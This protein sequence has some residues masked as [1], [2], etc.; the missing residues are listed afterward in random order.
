MREIESADVVPA[1]RVGED[2]FAVVDEVT[3]KLL[4]E[5]DVSEQC[6]SCGKNHI[7]L[8]TIDNGGVPEYVCLECLF[9][10]PIFNTIAERAVFQ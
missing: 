3:G 9:Q 6:D 4:E 5:L 7:V 1:I 10:Y 2:V 8:S